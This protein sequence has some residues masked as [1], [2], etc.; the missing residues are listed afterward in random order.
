MLIFWICVQK[1]L[2]QLLLMKNAKFTKG[3][4]FEN[5]KNNDFCGAKTG[6]ANSLLNRYRCCTLKDFFRKQTLIEIII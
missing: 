5:A 4:K 6:L 2:L 1:V 3:T